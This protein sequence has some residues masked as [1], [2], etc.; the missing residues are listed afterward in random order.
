[1]KTRF[2][3][4][5]WFGLSLTL[6]SCWLRLLTCAEAATVLSGNVSGTWTSNGSPYILSAD[7]TVAYNQT[8]TIQ[9]GTR[10]T[11][12]PGVSLRVSGG[13]FAV[14]TPEQPITISGASPTNYWDRIQISNS[15]FTNRFVY[16]KISEGTYGLYLYVDSDRTLVVDISHSA[17]NN[18]VLFCIWGQAETPASGSAILAPL[19]HNNIFENFASA[20]EFVNHSTGRAFMNP[21]ITANIFQNSRPGFP[22]RAFRMSTSVGNA[23]KSSPLFLNNV[24]SRCWGGV[25]IDST[26]FTPMI[27]NNVFVDNQEAVDAYNYNIA[28]GPPLDVRF[29]CFFQNTYSFGVAHHRQ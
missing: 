23:N 7:C 24:V 8:L 19:I 20:C 4:M 13:I 12:L 17:L 2:R 21:V 11:I 28:H 22:N 25:L 1:M 6:L 14:G 26:N 27:R 5:R 9:P 18:F 29:N 15:T 3:S 10:V 16:C